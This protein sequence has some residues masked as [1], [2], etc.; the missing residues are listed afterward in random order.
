M[1]SQTPLK[2]M[3]WHV[4]TICVSPGEAIIDEMFHILGFGNQISNPYVVLVLKYGDIIHTEHKQT[5]SHS[6]EL[7]TMSFLAFYSQLTS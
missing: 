6:F 1:I 2:F 3:T 7:Y 4:L 5:A